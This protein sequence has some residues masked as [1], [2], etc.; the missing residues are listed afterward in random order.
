MASGLD[1]SGW[2]VTVECDPERA[3]A[4]RAV[5]IA[6]PRVQ[7]LTADWTELQVH[8]PF[9][10]F[11]C[12]GGGKR[13]EPEAVIAMLAPGGLLV[14]DDFTPC[15]SWPPLHDGRLDALRLRY[16]CHEKLVATQVAVSPEET[17]ILAARRS[18]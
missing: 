12:D 3:S 1:P 7:V 17:C 10:I 11:F 5:H 6:D 16:L 15:S 4:A 8:G 9:D 14:L 18:D 13:T 2:I